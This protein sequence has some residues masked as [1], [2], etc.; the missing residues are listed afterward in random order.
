MSSDRAG[1][2]QYGDIPDLEKQLNEPEKEEA[3]LFLI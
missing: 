3:C 2:L 1:K